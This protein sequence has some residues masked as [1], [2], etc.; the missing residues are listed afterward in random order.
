M[1]KRLLILILFFSL[2]FFS[3]KNVFSAC[4]PA[5]CG[6][7]NPLEPR[8]TSPDQCVAKCCINPNPGGGGGGGGGGGTAGIDCPAGTIA[9]TNQVVSIECINSGIGTAQAQGSCCRWDVS[10]G[11]EVGMAGCCLRNETITYACVPINYDPVGSHESSS[12][13]TTVGWTCDGNDLSSS[14][15]VHVY[16]GGTFI[17][18]ATANQARSDIAST[19]GGYANHGFTF[20]TPN[21]LID[22]ASHNIYT[23][24]INPDGGN[25]P[26]L[27]NSPRTI[28]CTPSCT[29][30]L[31]PSSNSINSGSTVQLQASITASS[32]IISNVSFSSSNTSAVTVSPSSDTSASYTTTASAIGSGTST[33]TASVTMSGATRCSDTATVSVLSADP[34]WQVEDG[35]IVASGDIISTVPSTKYFNVVGLG[36]FPGVPVYNGSLLVTPGVVSNPSWAWSANTATNQSRLFNYSYFANLVP[37]D[38]I[39]T[40]PSSTSIATD[41]SDQDGYDWY[42][43]TGNLTL[44]ASDLLNR[45]VILFVDGNLTIDGNINVTDNQGFFVTFVNGTISIN[46]SVTGS[47]SLEGL[48]LSNSTFSTGVGTSPI[49]IRGSIASY[50]GISFERDL[51]D[52]SS[53]AEYIEFAPDQVAMFPEKLMLSRT[54]WIEVAP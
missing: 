1:K 22:G 29:V 21:T 36:G 2:T 37:S 13:T 7:P 43:H 28:S 19:C 10:D 25:N 41:I 51:A 49:N 14:I 33:I 40:D 35:D 16:D 30:D 48:Y 15:D 17:G 3:S 54:K 38:I 4:N 6:T 47:P 53:P 50:G 27:T 9:D 44:S 5:E 20:T 45:K 34:W 18:M 8:C 42:K 31:L 12:C 24:A 11:C 32:G 52:D 23:Y 39:F 46:P 26:L